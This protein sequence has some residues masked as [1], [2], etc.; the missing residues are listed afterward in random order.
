MQKQRE[1]QVR[2]GSRE[3]MT[4]AGPAYVVS[5]IRAIFDAVWA[6]GAIAPRCNSSFLLYMIADLYAKGEPPHLGQSWREGV[7]GLRTVLLHVSAG[8]GGWLSCFPMQWT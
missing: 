1:A 3:Y 6:G 2:G 4:A 5:A 7:A 8:D